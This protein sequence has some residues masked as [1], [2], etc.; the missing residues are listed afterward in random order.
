MALIRSYFY[1]FD[2]KFF[3]S[4]KTS[5]NSFFYNCF[6]RPFYDMSGRLITIIFFFKLIISKNI[7]VISRLF[8]D[9]NKKIFILYQGLV[10]GKHK[11]SFVKKF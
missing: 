2:F 7:R 6:L 4:K 3:F 1:W 8:V 10:L 9:I 5:L 11:V